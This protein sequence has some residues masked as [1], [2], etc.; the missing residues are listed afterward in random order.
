MFTVSDTV[1]ELWRGA[2][3]AVELRPCHAA[4]TSRQSAS[5]Y[6]LHEGLIGFTGEE[7]L[8][9]IKYATIEKDKPVQAGEIDRW[10]AWHHRQIL[11]GGAGA[12]GKQP[13][14]PR[15]SY[16]DDG[17]RRYQSD[18]LTDPITVG[19]GA[20]DDDRDAGLRRRQGS[21]EDQR[22]R[23]GPATSASSTC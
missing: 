3:F 7:G 22:L 6:V 9:E 13:F 4:S 5:I 1:Q 8:Q 2:C 21:R 23:E 14:Q 19:A 12:D 16:F 11:G 18:F 20:V 15:F 17:R 10:L